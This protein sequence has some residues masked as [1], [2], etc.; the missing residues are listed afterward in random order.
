MRTDSAS[1]YILK[2]LHRKEKQHRCSPEAGG[3]E[4]SACHL[5]LSEA[6]QTLSVVSPKYGLGS[7]V[8]LSHKIYMI[9]GAMGSRGGAVRALGCG[10]WGRQKVGKLQP[11]YFIFLSV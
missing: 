8:C 7:W 10:T 3:A 11:T 4:S 6:A 1:E 9:P 5:M 2:H